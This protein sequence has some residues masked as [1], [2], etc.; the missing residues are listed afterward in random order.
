MGDENPEAGIVAA[1]QAL[2]SQI[3]WKAGADA[4]HLD[5]RKRRGHLPPEYTL[6]DYAN[7]I[8]AIL[9][10]DENVVYR[11]DV[12]DTTYGAVGGVYE[13]QDWLVIFGLDGIMETAFPPKKLE[14]Y[15]TRRGF[16]R[17]GM[18]RELSQ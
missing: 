12:A 4:R 5:K 6:A 3:R 15:L 8:R 11:Y 7:L 10:N 13:G 16:V 1:I 14:R 9:N 18:M 17:L 2:R